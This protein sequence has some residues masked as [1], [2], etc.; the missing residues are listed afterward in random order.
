MERDPTE[1]E[2][3]LFVEQL[4]IAIH[5]NPKEVAIPPKFANIERGPAL[6]RPNAKSRLLILGAARK[7]RHRRFCFGDKDWRFDLQGINFTGDFLP[8]QK[9]KY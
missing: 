4:D 5:Q 2:G 8:D 6:C 9:D 1:P 7:R 3:R